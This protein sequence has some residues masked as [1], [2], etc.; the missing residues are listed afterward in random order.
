MNPESLT[1]S[2]AINFGLAFI[3]LSLFSIFKKQPSNASIYYA[4]R[5]SKRHH[6]HFEQSFT[7]SRFLPSVAW[8]PRALRVTEDEV[9]DIG[10]LDALIIIRLFKFGIYFFG[11]CSLIGLV[12]LLPINFGDQDEQSSIYHSMDPFTISNIS[13]GSNRLGFPSCLWLFRF[14]RVEYFATLHIV[15]LKLEVFFFIPQALGAFYVLVVDI[16][17]WI[18][19]VVQELSRCFPASFHLQEY[20]GISVKRI[21]L[22]RNLRHQPDR[23]N[24]LVRQVPF[25]NEHNAYGCSVDHFFSKHHPNSYCSYQMIYNGKDIEDL[26][27]QA[28]YVARKIEDLRGKLT[29]KKRDKESLLLDV[30]QEDDVKIALFEEKQ[31]EIVRKIRQLQNESMLKGKELPVAFVTFKSRRG[32]ALVSQTQQHSHPLIWIT[33]MVPEPRDVSWRSLE[34]PFKILPLCKIG[35][36]VAASLLTI[37]FAVPVTAVQGIAKLEKL[38][39]W[40]P[41]AMAMELIPGLSSII[42][43]YLP[44]AILKGFI[45]V[46]PFAML[47]MAK[48]G[49][50]ISK[51]KEEIKACN[52]VFYFLV[53][54]V[55][56]LSL[57][58]GSLLDELGEYFTHPR[59]IPSHLASAVSS[60]ADFFVTYILTDGLSGFSLEILQPGLLVW[61]SV[62]SHT[63]GGSGD[64]ENPYLY[65]LPY[66]RIIPSVS[67]SIIIGMVYAVV[68]PLLLPFLVGYF[69]L[70]YVV[71]VNQIEDVYETAY[72]TCGQY[73]PYVHHYIFVGIILMQITMIGLFGLK[74][75][76][77][78]S[79]ATIPLLLLTIMFNEYCKIR[80]LPAF[81]HYSVKDAVEHDE[82]DRK[83]GK[84]EINSENARSAYCQP[85][86][87]SANFVASKSTSSQPL[88][89]SL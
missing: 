10:G 79:I 67:L 66:F 20:D 4:R 76:P 3:V 80:F 83:F 57:I 14:E 61:D 25:C 43:G 42:T 72:D 71:Y 56:F 74:S 37:F 24:V 45:Y 49:G 47:G 88:V 17:L 50:S 36:V 30:S 62:K 34:I 53:G 5:L 81:R 60:Q 12:V 26:L 75:K 6:V 58:S 31:Q 32:A 7:L 29:V 55:F 52:M 19:S 18:I 9:L 65:S 15:C 22:L 44:S 48:L 39:K 86:L 38:K 70:G 11:I 23:F 51:S 73:W 1:A 85:T 64:E 87:Q 68:A 21:Q 54:N 33:E 40:F 35:V 28:K 2:A 59:S 16:I 82:L 27:H 13:A 46:V 63:V 77:S 8:I 78:A 41:P 84:M 69:Y 89:S